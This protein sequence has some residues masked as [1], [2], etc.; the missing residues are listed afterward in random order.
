MAFLTKSVLAG[1]LLIN[2]ACFARAVSD[3]AEIPLEKTRRVA[4]GLDKVLRIESLIDRDYMERKNYKANSY[5]IL[6]T[7]VQFRKFYHCGV[8]MVSFHT[9][10]M[11]DALRLYAIEG[12]VCLM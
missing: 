12:T 7:S 8:N 10:P 5:N 4:S 3:S 9:R 2:I 1:L 11:R 6:F